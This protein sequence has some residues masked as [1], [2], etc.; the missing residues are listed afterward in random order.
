MMFNDIAQTSLT[1]NEVII[2]GMENLNFQHLE[3]ICTQKVKQV[4]INSVCFQGIITL[5]V[6]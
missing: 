4:I 5:R 1:I 2:F 3:D 6:I